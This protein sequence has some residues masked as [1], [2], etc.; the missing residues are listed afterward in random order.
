MS[1]TIKL[2]VSQYINCY[3]VV[4][5]EQWCLVIWQNNKEKLETDRQKS[6]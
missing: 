2:K 1:A 4:K 3:Q 5:A 6:L